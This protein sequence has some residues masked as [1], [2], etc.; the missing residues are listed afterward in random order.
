M[1]ESL[2]LTM[3]ENITKNN[4]HK[5]NELLWQY[6][7]TLQFQGIEQLAREKTHRLWQ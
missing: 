5:I 1:T 2:P 7:N 4:Y 3:S 6:V